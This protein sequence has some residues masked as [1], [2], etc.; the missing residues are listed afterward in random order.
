MQREDYVLRL[1]DQL[2]VFMRQITWMRDQGN[3]DEALITLVRGQ[4]TL[5]GSFA[6]EIAG[7]NFEQQFER[8][9]QSETPQRGCEKVYAYALMLDRAADVYRDREQTALVE[10]A[11]ML[12]DTMRTMA[13][14]RFGELAN[15]VAQKLGALR[16]D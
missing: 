4:E 2:G 6:H 7:W 3:D 9:V 13:Q 10:G 8:L 1:I 11:Q 5:M 12:A 15:A 14:E 16:G